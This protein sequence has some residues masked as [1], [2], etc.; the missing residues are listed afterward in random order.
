M[1]KRYLPALAR[2]YA[3]EASFQWIVRE[4][5]V[6]SP[7]HDARDMLQ[8]DERLEA[9]LD[10]L[11]VAGPAGWEACVEELS[12]R[13]PGEIFAAGVLAL[14]SGER[15]R[16][17]AIL[18]AAEKPELARALA[19][20]LGWLPWEQARPWIDSLAGE[21]PVSRYLAVAGAA[22]HRRWLPALMAEALRDPDARVRAR[23]FKACGE[24]GRAE[25]LPALLA[26]ADESDPGCRF[27]AAWSATLLDPGACD[28]LVPWAAAPG[29]FRETA[30]RLYLRALSPPEALAWID[31]LRQPD[32]RLRIL[33]HGWIGSAGSMPW[34]LE[35][36]RAPAVAR[37]AGASITWI[38][39]AEF[40]SG[41]LGAH[42]QPDLED[43]LE[44][45][46][47]AEAL[48]RDYEWPN[49]PATEA[50]WRSASAAYDARKV[51]A[52]GKE[53]GA[54]AFAH[55]H[56]LGKQCHR[57]DG[58]LES[59]LHRPGRPLPECRG[60]MTR[61]SLAEQGSAA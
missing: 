58:A 44:E 61:Q 31:A 43:V 40:L 1:A 4:R 39:G 3:E 20:A 6:R 7:N 60:R 11:R 22:L 29:P 46:G 48:D 52:L 37:L 14:E 53:K 56:A 59:A 34:L 57:L 24:N 18:A 8:M 16:L 49:P 12:W 54:D 23:A 25:T 28:R 21:G 33:G 36:M 45:E 55:L 51:Y 19:S 15:K 42:A 38:T 35:Q 26:A 5:A 13:E 17:D 2:R 41:R 50:W 32:L 30:L 10:G 9:Y 27:R 47:Q